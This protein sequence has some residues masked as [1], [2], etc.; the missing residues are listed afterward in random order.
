MS[1]EELFAF[2][3]QSADLPVAD[4]N[5]VGAATEGPCVKCDWR[6]DAQLYEGS[7]FI[8]SKVVAEAFTA[9]LTPRVIPETLMKHFAYANDFFEDHI[10]HV[11]HVDSPGIAVMGFNDQQQ[12]F[13]FLVDGTHRMMSALRSGRKFEAFVLG[14]RDTAIVARITTELSN[15]NFFWVHPSLRIAPHQGEFHEDPATRQGNEN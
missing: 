7:G 2:L 8:F 10:Q 13:V 6:D 11:S 14:A 1:D 15:T 4:G 9:T 5:V 12:A 3:S